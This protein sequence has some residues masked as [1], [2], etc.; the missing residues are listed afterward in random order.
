M[1]WLQRLC[2][3]YEYCKSER[4][5]ALKQDNAVA[6]LPVGEKKETVPIEI[7]LNPDATVNNIRVI[8]NDENRKIVIPCTEESANRTNRKTP[9][10][11]FDE[12]R[13]MAGDYYDYQWDGVK[14]AKK[15]KEKVSGLHKE[16]IA[17]LEKLCDFSSGRVRTQLEVILSYLKQERLVHDLLDKKIF[18][19]SIPKKKIFCSVEKKEEEKYPIYQKI[20]R[21]NNQGIERCAVRVAVYTGDPDELETKIW[22]M[23]EFWDTFEK[24]YTEFLRKE[25]GTDLCYISGKEE[26]VAIKIDAIVKGKAK[27]I[28]SNDDSKYRGRFETA[29]EAMCVG[30][31]STQKAFNTLRWLYEKQGWNRGNTRYIIWGTKDEKLPSVGERSVS[32]LSDILGR[33]MSMSKSAPTTYDNFARDVCRA[34]DGY[35]ED[36]KHDSKIVVLGIKEATQGRASVVYY[37]EISGSQFLANIEK[38]HRSACWFPNYYRRGKEESQREKSKPEY[39]PFMGAPSLTDIVLKAYKVSDAEV[40]DS[41]FTA[42]FDR[43]VPCVV[44][45]RSVPSNLVRTLFHRVTNRVAFGD[46]IEHRAACSVACSMIRKYFNDRLASCPGK[47]KEEI[48]VSLQPDYNDRSYQFGRLLAYAEKLE[49]YVLYKEGTKRLTNAEKLM[50]QF[51][52]CPL[53][54]WNNIFLRL[55][56][57]RNKMKGKLDSGGFENILS[58]EMDEILSRLTDGAK[59]IS[60]ELN[61]PLTELFVIGY[62][63]QKNQ[64]RKSKSAEKTDVE[65][66]STYP[67]KEE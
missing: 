42:T 21:K 64:F 54:T 31:S 16:Y 6:L 1:S 28:S 25:R 3:T 45:G 65:T 2:E 58:S 34:V 40:P 13:Y 20:N 59:N 57:Y 27:L 38:W 56:P 51:V 47:G 30:Y 29:D 9:H 12:I 14:F 48:E 37:R 46:E 24:F 49:E 35:K 4:E 50:N 61:K 66:E 26:V 60:K 52:K 55:Q 62:S 10:I 11:L 17:L 33:K 39:V 19:G 18:K 32:F 15:E 22:R 5:A 44:E 43:L 63:A 53:K 41:L 8:E 36:L 23:P 7:T 67:G